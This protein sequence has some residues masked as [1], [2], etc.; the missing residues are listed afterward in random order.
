MFLHGVIRVPFA[1][2]DEGAKS[3]Q[4]S[5]TIHHSTLQNVLENLNLHE[6]IFFT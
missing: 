1:P 3:L 2:E 4:N 5:V 6:R